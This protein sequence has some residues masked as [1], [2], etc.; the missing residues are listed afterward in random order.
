MGLTAMFSS[1]HA[2]FSGFSEVHLKV[3][4]T[5]HKAFVEVSEEGTEASAA[6]VV[7]FVDRIAK[8]RTPLPVEFFCDRAFVFLIRD[9]ESKN[10]LFMGN[11]Q[12]PSS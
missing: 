4:K 2:N 9:N 5:I 8:P 1:Q 12:E 7:V 10:L 3:S 11:F 6:T